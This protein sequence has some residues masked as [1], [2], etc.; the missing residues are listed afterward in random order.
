MAI[1]EKN[2]VFDFLGKMGEA[3]QHGVLAVDEK[4]EIRVFNHF[5]GLVLAVKVQ[6]ALG[7]NWREIIPESRLGIALGDGPR[8]IRNYYLSFKEKKIRVTQ[9][10][11]C[12]GRKVSGVVEFWE[13]YS[14]IEKLTCQLKE[15]LEQN[16]LLDSILNSAYEDVGAVDREGRVIY[17]NEKGAIRLGVDRRAV[18]GRFMREI[19][20]DCLMEKVARSG[21]PQMGKLWHVKDKYVPVMVLPLIEN[22]EVKGA[23][24]KSVFRDLHEA[25]DFIKKIR[26][27]CR[28]TIKSKQ[29]S[30]NGQTGSR[31]TFADIV[32]ESPAMVTAKELA[33]RSAATEA[34]V[35][36]LGESG[37][38]KELFAHAIHSASTRK[39]GPF[40]K[41]NC[42]S[43][44]ES[45]L[46]S[47]LFGYEEGAFTGA[48][49][50]GKPGKF[51]L[52]NGGT[53][54]LDEV[55]DMSLNMQAKLLRVLQEGEIEKIGSTRTRR[56]DVRV[57]AATNHDLKT[58]VQRGEFREDLY[59]RLEVILIRIPPLRERLQDIQ[60]L[61]PHLV[62]QLCKKYG[63]DPFEIAPPV[64]EVLK[65]YSWP[66][67]VRELGNVLEGAMCLADKQVIEVA[68]LP[69]HFVERTG[70]IRCLL[71]APGNVQKANV[72]PPG[73]LVCTI[74]N[75]VNEAEKTAIERALEFTRGNKRKAARVLGIARSTFYEKLKRY[76][77]A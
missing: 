62:S 75:V 30:G 61:V 13:D 68:D 54:F 43:I 47:E 18:I 20:S 19:R 12:Q 58:K 22:G 14:E 57:I 63:K 48:R 60:L 26:P 24:C 39:D 42:A 10:S 44:P 2:C 1:R 5:C 21:V 25:E 41:V 31:Y 3:L 27:Y 53:I 69:P 8:E 52:A 28:Q 11:L 55:G 64:Y 6:D 45:L 74:G 71:E 66:G 33:R 35:L 9:F 51:E 34:T 70:K 67:N 59:Y 37:T 16:R 72:P 32:G 4:G 49:K 46:E 7:K 23:V 29:A 17:A 40:L 15:A 56:V 38:G 36:L 50:G 76:N 73:P 77:L 65:A